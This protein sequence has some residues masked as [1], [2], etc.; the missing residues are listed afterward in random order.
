MRIGIDFDN[1]LVCFDDIFHKAALDKKLIPPSV[2]KKKEAIRDI[3]RKA[4]NEDAW[5]ELQ[6]AVY[7]DLIREAPAY[8]GAKDFIR[9]ARKKSIPIFVISH[10]TAKPFLGP[11]YDLHQAAR[12][13]LFVHSLIGPEG[14]DKENVYMELTKEKKLERIAA[15]S[16]THF[17][18]DLPEFLL[19]PR[20]PPSVERILFDPNNSLL[21]HFPHI[22][23]KSWAAIQRRLFP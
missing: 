19:E 5:T 3:M 10:K 12:D 13:W 1:T 9:L 21:P 15:Q 20:F 14:F 22:R 7:G 16:C 4:G 17:I 11:A 18:D 23:E 2:P 8:P 6:G